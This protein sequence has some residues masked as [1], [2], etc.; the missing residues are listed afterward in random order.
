VTA[1]L[2]GLQSFEPS[3]RMC[4]IATEMSQA[5]EFWCFLAEIIRFVEWTSKQT[6]LFRNLVPVIGLKSIH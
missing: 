1:D 3:S 5:S 6:Y 2:C 4:C